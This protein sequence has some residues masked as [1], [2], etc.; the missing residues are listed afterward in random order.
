MVTS[1]FLRRVPLLPVTVRRWAGPKASEIWSVWLEVRAKSVQVRVAPSRVSEAENWVS[2]LVAKSGVTRV[3][4]LW[5]N[6]MRRSLLWICG[7]VPEST[8]AGGCGV[9]FGCPAFRPKGRISRTSV[10]RA[11]AGGRVMGTGIVLNGRIANDSIY[12]CFIG[13]VKGISRGR[14]VRQCLPQARWDEGR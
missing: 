12:F 11:R 6:S 1:T 4:R 14:R 3:W 5:S 13:I 10:V 9:L 7:L 8:E 2:G